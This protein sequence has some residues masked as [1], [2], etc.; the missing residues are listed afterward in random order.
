MSSVWVDALCAGCGK[1][2]EAHDKAI[3]VIP[4]TMK[5]TGSY[6]SGS[7]E[8]GQ[9]RVMPSKGRKGKQK[10]EVYHEKCWPGV[11]SPISMK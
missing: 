11:A 3:A 9:M 8:R 2:L 10:A 1:P 5:A 7:G 6:A 4:A